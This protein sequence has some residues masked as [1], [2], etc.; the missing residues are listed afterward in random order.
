MTSLT[1]PPPSAV[2]VVPAT[3]GPAAQATPCFNLLMAGLAALL[4]AVFVLNQWAASHDLVTDADILSWTLLLLGAALLSGLALGVMV[5]HG[6]APGGAARLSLPA[7]YGLS[8]VGVLIFLAGVGLDLLWRTLLLAYPL[9][10]DLL[11]PTSLLTA[12]GAVL[13]GTG[14]LRAVWQ[15]SADRGGPVAWRIILPALVAVTGLLIT[16]ALFT[17]RVN[18]LVDP[19]YVAPPPPVRAPVNEV[20]RMNADGTGQTRLLTRP[21]HFFWGPAWSPDG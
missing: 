7:G 16:L 4:V 10:D 18:P 2:L 17:Q 19:A 15:R 3:T 11:R 14:P 5:Y 21:G 8:L 13:I 12:L 1:S 9:G 20:Y 6:R